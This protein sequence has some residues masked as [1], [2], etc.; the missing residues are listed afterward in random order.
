[1]SEYRDS[2]PDDATRARYDEAV[3]R[4]GAILAAWQA[5][6]ARDGQLTETAA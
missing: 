6:A 4:A 1:M 2:L 3:A 5:D